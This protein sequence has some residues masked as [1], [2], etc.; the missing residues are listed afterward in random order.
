M[1]AVARSV[2]LH[3]PHRNIRT[4][5]TSP[6]DQSGTQTRPSIPVLEQALQQLVLS[7]SSLD[8][9]MTARGECLL[10]CQGELHLEYTLHDLTLVQL[11]P[12]Q[13]W[14]RMEGVGILVTLTL[15]KWN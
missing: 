7:D 5:K 4:P 6:E 12:R 10:C 3:L 9:T 14:P 15:T 1:Y 11:V 2:S 8:V 13:H